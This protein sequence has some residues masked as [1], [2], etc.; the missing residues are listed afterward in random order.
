M[1]MLIAGQPISSRSASARC[2]VAIRA[3]SARGRRHGHMVLAHLDRR[4]YS[5]VLIRTRDT[6]SSVLLSCRA[7]VQVV[8]AHVGTCHDLLVSRFL[9]VVL[10]LKRHLYPMLAIGQELV[11]NGHEV[12]WCGPENVLRP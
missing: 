6:S 11:R 1:S 9:I 12:V 5:T 10:P 4:P 3:A 8:A 2:P 7:T